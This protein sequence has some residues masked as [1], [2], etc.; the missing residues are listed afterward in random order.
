MP[1]TESNVLDAI[2]K[3]F[4]YNEL[5]LILEIPSPKLS[6]IEQHSVPDRRQLFVSALFRSAPKENCNWKKVNSAIKRVQISQWASLK[7]SNSMTKSS[8]F[9]SQLSSLATGGKY[10]CLK[11]CTCI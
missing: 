1:F 2:T 4:N 9:E 5:G 11:S 3:I 8:S 10:V 6:E 7:G